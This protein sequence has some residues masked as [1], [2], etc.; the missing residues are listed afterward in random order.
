[1]RPELRAQLRRQK[2]RPRSS[3][4]LWSQVSGINVPWTVGQRNWMRGKIRDSLNAVFSSV[5]SQP[6]SNTVIMSPQA[7]DAYK[8]ALM[9]QEVK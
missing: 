7:Y 6:R 2:A 1:M 4:R 9:Y 8:S 3:N 5:A